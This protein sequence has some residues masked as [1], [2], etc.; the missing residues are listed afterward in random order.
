MI[1]RR[2][3]TSIFCIFGLIWRLWIS[4]KADNPTAGDQ[5]FTV[6][7]PISQ[8]LYLR[9]FFFCSRQCPL[10]LFAV[11]QVCICTGWQ[12][13]MYI[14][15]TNAEFGQWLISLLSPIANINIAKYPQRGLSTLFRHWPKR[16]NQNSLCKYS[17]VEVN[18]SLGDCIKVLL[19]Y[20]YT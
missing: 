8:I 4:R 16:N 11:N 18:S 15:S 20:L 12:S 6:F 5:E 3:C 7:V 9:C 17:T 1:C 19:Y 14:L 2:L 13:N 10:K